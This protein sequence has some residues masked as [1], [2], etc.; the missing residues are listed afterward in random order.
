MRL[1]QRYSTKLL[2]VD[3]KQQLI[4][5]KRGNCLITSKISC[6]SFSFINKSYF[7]CLLEVQLLSLSHLRESFCPNPHLWRV[8]GISFFSKLFCLNYISIV[9]TFMLLVKLDVK[10]KFTLTMSLYLKGVSVTLLNNRDLVL[11]LIID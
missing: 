2:V 8:L 3:S 7:C 5:R 10:F 1:L 6:N 4:Y 9:G 11:S